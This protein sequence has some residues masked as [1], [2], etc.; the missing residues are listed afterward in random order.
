MTSQKILI[1]LALLIAALL[2]LPM[3][4]LAAVDSGASPGPA[5][6]ADTDCSAVSQIPQAECEALVALYNGT[7]GPGWANADGWLVTDTPCSWYGVTCSAGHV[8]Q[9]ALNDNELKGSLPA[10]LG[11]LAGLQRLSLKRNLLSGAAPVELGSLTTLT[12]LDLTDNQ[13]SGP[14]PAELGSLASLQKL[15]LWENDLSGPIPPELGNLSNLQELSLATNELSGTIPSELGGLDSLTY[16]SLGGN[17]LSGPIPPELGAL[18]SLQQLILPSNQLSGSLP[19]SLGDLTSLFV[20]QLSNNQLSGPIPPELGKLT[21]MRMMDLHSNQLSGPIPAEL[22]KLSHL[23]ELKLGGNRLSGAIPGALGDLPD[24]YSVELNSNLLSGVVPDKI[25]DVGQGFGW[26]ELNYNLLTGGPA[27]GCLDGM[28]FGWNQ[29]QTV[30]PSDLQATAQSSSTVQLTWTPIV[31]TGD[32]GQYE[33]GHAKNGGPLAIHG[34]S[35]DK[36]SSGYLA[37]D[38][39]P[40]ATYAFQV[41]TFTASHPDGTEHVSNDLWSEFSEAVTVT[42]PGTPP[43]PLNIY[44]PLLVAG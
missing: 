40:G 14:V 19:A 21:G 24:V 36:T 31:Y 3:M 17:D 43:P 25:C 27:S 44:L 34:V 26:L 18:S 28:T 32:V 7:T 2:L 33:I 23:Q 4:S 11:D 15:L 9:L 1:S 22:G 35:A 37:A 30:P 13:L 29:T 5:S 8:T 6:L 41:R 42:M 20:L 39:I 38:L 16:L 10:K 12:S